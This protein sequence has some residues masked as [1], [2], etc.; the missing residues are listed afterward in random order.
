MDTLLD[1]IWYEAGKV[2]LSFVYHHL[3]LTLTLCVIMGVIN[4]KARSQESK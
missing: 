2:F 1:S 4:A 3:G